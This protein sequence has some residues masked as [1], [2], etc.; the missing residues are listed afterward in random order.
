MASGSPP[1]SPS[2]PSNQRLES[3]PDLVAPL[4]PPDVFG[5]MPSSPDAAISSS[6]VS[7]VDPRLSRLD[8][9]EAS[10]PDP[11]EADLDGALEP[12]QPCTP[13]L[14]PR[15]EA[16]RFQ[17]SLADFVGRSRR[18]LASTY[19]FIDEKRERLPPAVRDPLAKMPTPAFSIGARAGRCHALGLVLVLVLVVG[20]HESE[21]AQRPAPRYPGRCPHRSAAEQRRRPSQVRATPS[22]RPRRPPV[23]R[24]LTELEGKYPKD[25]RIPLAR[26]KLELAAKKHTAAV[27][28]VGKLLT[29]IRHSATTPRSRARSGPRCRPRQRRTPPIP[30]SQARWARGAR[31]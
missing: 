29:T 20:K 23:S 25:T 5:R 27:A 28:T 24:L 22:S 6:P 4:L 14:L 15:S 1:S 16:D 7:V 19:D 9:R 2:A 13:V 21:K 3:I 17:E 30:C 26:L 10:S 8:S 11:Y 18:W 12:S 31:T